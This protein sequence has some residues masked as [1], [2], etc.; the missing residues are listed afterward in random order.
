MIKIYDDLPSL[1]VIPSDAT[2]VYDFTS[3]VHNF[4]IVNYH[5][6]SR[7]ELIEGTRWLHRTNPFRPEFYRRIARFDVSSPLIGEWN[8]IHDLHGRSKWRVRQLLFGNA[9][10]MEHVRQFYLFYDFSLVPNEFLDVKYTIIGDF[11]VGGEVRQ[12]QYVK[13]LA[14]TELYWRLC[15]YMMKNHYRQ[16]PNFKENPPVFIHG[17]LKMT[18]E[19]DVYLIDPVL[20]LKVCEE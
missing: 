19:D 9:P 2:F 6:Y 12:R 10:M 4:R 16:V 14:M 13:V 18:H 7:K 11:A 8:L 17:E 1:Q 15:V 20:D 5:P 3:T